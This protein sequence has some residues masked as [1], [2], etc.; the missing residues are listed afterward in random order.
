VAQPIPVDAPV[1]TTD[2]VVVKSFTGSC[3]N[4]RSCGYLAARC[5]ET[6]LVALPRYCS[7][8]KTVATII[9]EAASFLT[10]AADDVPM[11]GD[12]DIKLQS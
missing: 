9:G 11:T 4:M 5:S 8:G 10:A 3:S 2:R 12:D 6:G 7:P 1:M